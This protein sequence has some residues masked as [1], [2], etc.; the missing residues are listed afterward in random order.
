MVKPLLIAMVGLPRSGKTTIIQGLTVEHKAP[1]VSR[2]SIRLCLHN[3]PY[4]TLAEPF[5]KAI[6]GVMIRSLFHAG[7]EVVI[8]D[9]TNWS[10][11]AR[12]WCKD[13]SWDTV[14]YV[15]D[16]PLNVCKERAVATNQAYL[17]P[18]LDEMEARKEPLDASDARYEDWKFMI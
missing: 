8:Y 18:V 5:V 14:F 6:S 4:E 10:K 12:A 1:I 11:A 16:T 17:L 3:Q 7:H 13:P 2:D 9:E 15:V